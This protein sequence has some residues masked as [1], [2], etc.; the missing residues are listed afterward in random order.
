MRSLEFLRRPSARPRN[1]LLKLPETE[2]RS[3][4]YW[5]MRSSRPTF[6]FVSGKYGGKTA[7]E[8]STR[9]KS[10]INSTA[11][12]SCKRLIM[13]AEACFEIIRSTGLKKLHN[14]SE[15]IYSTGLKK[16]TA[17][18]WKI[19]S[20]CLKKNYSTCLKKM[21]GTCLGGGWRRLPAVRSD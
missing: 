13:A 3:M 17:P 5:T 8:D 19:F 11:I 16:I 4:E 14:W 6:W 12:S 20:S 18:V 1:T 21:Y 7:K 15:T 2:L 9:A 10:R